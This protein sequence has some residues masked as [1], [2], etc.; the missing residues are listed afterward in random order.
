MNNEGIA[1]YKKIQAKQ[2]VFEES[3]RGANAFSEN[4]IFVALNTSERCA[5]WGADAVFLQD[6]KPIYEVLNELC[7]CNKLDVGQVCKAHALKNQLEA[8]WPGVLNDDKTS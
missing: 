1:V 7:F 6:V 3:L 8:N 4:H 2:I 5:K